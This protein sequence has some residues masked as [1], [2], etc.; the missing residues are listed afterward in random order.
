MVKASNAGNTYRAYR[1][2]SLPRRL[3][4]KTKRVIMTPVR[5]ARTH[6]T[7]TTTGTAPTNRRHPKVRY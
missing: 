4:Y 1:V 2:T 3:Y 7:H 6:R 5:K